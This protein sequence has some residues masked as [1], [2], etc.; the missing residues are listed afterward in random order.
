M[1]DYKSVI[2]TIR[3]QLRKYIVDNG[4]K[5]LII[6]VS[7]GIDSLV[8][9]VLAKAVCDEMGIPLIG[10]SLPI[11]TN[12]KEEIDRALTT[13]ELFCSDFYEQDLSGAFGKL[14]QYFPLEIDRANINFHERIR[15]GNIK[16]RLRM[17]FLYDLANEHGGLVLSTDNLSE[18]YLGFW[19]LH[20][21]HADYGMVQNLWKTEIFELAE[22]MYGQFIKPDEEEKID[23]FRVT[24]N[25]VPTD[26][27]GVSTSDCDQFGVST[28]DEVDKTLQ[29]WLKIK[30]ESGNKRT[31]Q[32]RKSSVVKMHER[33]HFKRNWPIS[34]SREILEA[35]DAAKRALVIVDLQGDFMPDGTL[36]ITEGDLLAEKILAIRNNFDLVIFTKDWH[37]KD[38]CSF[39]ENGGPW[40]AHCVQFSKGADLDK[41][42]F[43][44]DDIVVVKGLAQDVDSY[45]GF[46]DNERK[47]KTG[48]EDI[49]RK[50]DIG[51][52]YIC[53]LATDYCVKLTALDSVDAG[54]ET[55]LLSDMCRGAD[56]GSGD[57]YRAIKEMADKGVTIIL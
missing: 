43:N 51:T 23:I 21:D 47:N 18:Y 37:P 44:I 25:A 31:E 46:W 12:T 36:A 55:F 24:I 56:I 8:C 52:V 6:G 13:G 16:A 19:T 38:H 22:Y 29:E 14:I 33:T 11:K 48:L 10:R 57:V 32:L 41:R 20:G 27:L 39:V 54:F 9:A 35:C 15:S 26:G 5:S 50:N 53:G 4:L 40:P 34:I 3:E 7:G 45:S 2:A 30:N 28:Y 49:L 42:V 17:M 1:K